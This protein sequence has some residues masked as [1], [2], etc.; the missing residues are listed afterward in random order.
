MQVS[1]SH[2]YSLNFNYELHGYDFVSRL[3]PKVADKMQKEFDFCYS[4]TNNQFGKRTEINTY[5]YRNAISVYIKFIHGIIKEDFDFNMMNQVLGKPQKIY[6][7]K[8]VC[9][10]N[11]VEMA[12]F[13]QMNSWLN[14]TEKTHVSIIA[15]ETKKEVELTYLCKALNDY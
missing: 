4:M 3:M 10:P 12:D 9:Y 15:M 11:L 5:H 1:G 7:K 6:V 13:D 14:K 2:L 8:M